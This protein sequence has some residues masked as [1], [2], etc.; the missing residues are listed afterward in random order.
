VNVPQLVLRTQALG[1]GDIFVDANFTN[2]G[3]ELDLIA[4]GDIVG[5]LSFTLTAPTIGLTATTG[6][7]GQQLTPIQVSGG[8]SG[9]VQLQLTANATANTVNNGNIFITDADSD[10]NASTPALLLST[11]SAG[12]GSPVD[13]TTGNFQ[14]VATTGG[15]EI[16]GS[17][18]ATSSLNFTAQTNILWSSGTTSAP[19]LT[20]TAIGDVGSSGNQV[21]FTTTTLYVTGSNLFLLSTND[22]FTFGILAVANTLDLTVT[23]NLNTSLIN[24]GTPT[25]LLLSTL[26]GGNINVDS[27]LTVNNSITF[28][29][30]GNI[31]QS[32]SGTIGSPEISLTANTGNIGSNAVP[33]LVSSGAS[34]TTQ[35]SLSLD[36]QANAPNN[37]DAYISDGDNDVSGDPALSLDSAQIGNNL[38]VTTTAGGIGI[39]DSAVSAGNS[40]TLQVQT[41]IFQAGGAGPL[42]SPSISLTATTGSIG[43]SIDPIVV[44]SRSDRQCVHNGRRCRS[45]YDLT[46]IVAWQ[47]F[48]GWHI[49]INCLYRQHPCLR[50]YFG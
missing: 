6:N 29:A 26:S 16:D 39:L 30:D 20:L 49:R 24:A 5:S 11:S 2:S 18:S 38:E 9:T 25:V 47:F 15:I 45:D 41:N 33:V 1:A 21:Q 48:C 43:T 4:D 37:G 22:T 46:G 35:L 40:I 8:N 32:G 42:G 14:L 12:T 19:S 23:G 10:V 31:V 34:G 27:S 7:I 36:A 13:G 44:S 28:T 3:G 50:R 17:L